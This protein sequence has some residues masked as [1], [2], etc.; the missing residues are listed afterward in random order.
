MLEGE[1]LWV[2][3][4]VARR[5]LGALDVI[6]CDDDLEFEWRWATI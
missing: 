2:D 1:L 5:A 3:L 6:G 4:I